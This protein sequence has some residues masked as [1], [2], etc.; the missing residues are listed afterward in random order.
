M[1]YFYDGT[2]TKSTRLEGTWVL[3]QA[4][5]KIATQYIQKNGIVK[6]IHCNIHIDDIES[7]DAPID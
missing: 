5:S 6:S 7:M 2:I 4:S 3:C 1:E